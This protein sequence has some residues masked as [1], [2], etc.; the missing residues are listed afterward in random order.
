MYHK[1]RHVGGV[2]RSLLNTDL[3]KHH[4]TS[5][6]GPILFTLFLKID[7]RGGGEAA[8][9]SRRVKKQRWGCGCGGLWLAKRSSKKMFEH[10][11]ITGR[12]VAVSEGV[13]STCVRVHLYL[14]AWV[15]IVGVGGSV[16]YLAAFNLP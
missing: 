4:R 6:I 13:R 10:I 7:R 14:W 16:A 9:E 5:D 15:R 1:V 2:G 8:N 11:M 3:I 12:R